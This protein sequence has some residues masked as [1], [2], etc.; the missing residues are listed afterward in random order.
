MKISNIVGSILSRG[1]LGKIS[2]EKV[3][4]QQT[5][6]ALPKDY[7][8]FTTHTFPF[9]RQLVPL[10]QR[11]ALSV[12]DVGCRDGQVYS[13]FP[14]PNFYV[15]V[16]LVR[17]VVEY[18]ASK[19]RRTGVADAMF[20]PFKDSVFDLIILRH[21]LEHV[22]NPYLVLQ[23]IRRVGKSNAIFGLVVPVTDSTV[24]DVAHY[25]AFSGAEVQ[26]LCSTIGATLQNEVYKEERRVIVALTKENT[27]VIVNV[28]NSSYSHRK[29]EKTTTVVPEEQKIDVTAKVKN[30]LPWDDY[31]I[32]IGSQRKTLSNFSNAQSGVQQALQIVIKHVTGK[33][34]VDFGCGAG[35][36]AVNLFR[37][38]NRYVGLDGSEIAINQANE[39]AVNFKSKCRFEH[40]LLDKPLDSKLRKRIG[41]FDVVCALDFLRHV[42]P[43]QI[44][45]AL[46]NAVQLAGT[47]I[48]F[49]CYAESA[50]THRHIEHS[51]Y[52]ISTSGT[53]YN[54][55][56]HPKEI[57]AILTEYG[58]V[59]YEQKLVAFSS[60]LNRYAKYIHVVKA[61]EIELV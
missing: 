48:I 45:T 20:L 26:N 50:P 59:I 24:T 40:A 3:L 52:G 14:S 7:D 4:L 12:L 51:I 42:N 19:G 34:V 47:I 31:D 37:H 21:V 53:V 11:E 57:H 30:E 16:D 22:V 18:A 25:Y 13:L 29:K 46:R 55:M 33:S 8:H 43:E 35:I 49:D 1:P 32:V 28:P 58:D 15:G 41:D 54:T 36:W 44:S 56:R 38:V 61:K 5:E 9:V 27:G 2:Y 6:R 60:E 39:Y 17:R 10:I 23:E